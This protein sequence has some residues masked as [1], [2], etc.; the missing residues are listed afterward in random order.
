[1][2]IT[3]KTKKMVENGLVL[4][5]RGAWIPLIDKLKAERFF[6]ERLS[7]GEVLHNK[8]WV[9]ISEAKTAVPVKESVST[10]AKPPQTPSYNHSQPEKPVNQGTDDFSFN[11]FL[12]E[13]EPFQPELDETNHSDI[14]TEQCKL[15]IKDDP[16]V[17]KDVIVDNA[18]Q[19]KKEPQQQEKKAPSFD[20]LQIDHNEHETVVL[21][22]GKMAELENVDDSL[23]SSKIA[24]ITSKIPTVSFHENVEEILESIEEFDEWERKARHRQALFFA[25]ASG[26]AAVIGSSAILVFLFI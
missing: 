15:M 18:D 9:S 25:I 12:S 24:R 14:T 3:F 2:D 16:E 6:I 5:E 1:M 13:E 17:K 22:T 26:V 10:A 20:S 4:D 21:P 11:D 8:R 23:I 19:V 7:A